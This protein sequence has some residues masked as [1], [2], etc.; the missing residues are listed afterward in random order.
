VQSELMPP[1]SVQE[2]D[3]GQSLRKAVELKASDVHFHSGYP[4][5]FR[6]N[7]RMQRMSETPL[8]Q[9]QIAGWVLRELSHEELTAFKTNKD[10]DFYEPDGN[11]N[12][13]SRDTAGGV[14]AC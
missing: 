4:P 11:Q 6:I 5:L 9:Q 7:G 14:T 1:G 2:F 12:E 8:T 10:C 13:F 3:F